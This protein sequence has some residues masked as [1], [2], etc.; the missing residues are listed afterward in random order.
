VT[1][2]VRRLSRAG[3]AFVL[4]MALLAAAC[5]DK[6]KVPGGILPKEK[7]SQVIWDLAQA[8]QYAALYIAKDSAK[9]DRKAETMK[10]YEAVFRLHHV[11]REQFSKSYRWYLD[12]PALNQ[13]LFDSVIAH[14]TQARSEMYDRPFYHPPSSRPISPSPAGLGGRG[15]PLPGQG[16]T[17]RPGT[18]MP[19]SPLRAGT[20][21]TPDVL[22][23]MQEANM[24]R[25]RDSLA[26]AHRK[27]DTAGM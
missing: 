1:G 18:A 19:G 13:V 15:K 9:S 11:T 6:T 24:R 27:I 17:V 25:I 16:M 5:S 10:L 4:S 22:R 7:M 2:G 8:D 20:L 23:R 3:Q 21:R 12:H 26:R 14:G